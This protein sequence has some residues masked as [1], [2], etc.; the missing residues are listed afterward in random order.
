MQLNQLQRKTPHQKAQRVGRGGSRGKTSGRGTKGQKARAGHR[1]FPQV[2]EQLKKL[3]KLRGYKQRSIQEK[4]L[5]VNLDALQKNFAAGDTI[6]PKILVERGL[7]R[8]RKGEV[9][10][11]KIL[12]QGEITKKFAITG[13]AISSSAREKIEKAGGTISS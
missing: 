2:R 5:P 1:I 12:G 3:P 8:Y 13:C 6:N 7:V 9:P 4:P 11:V 10:A